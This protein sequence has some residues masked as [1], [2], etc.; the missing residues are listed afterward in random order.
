MVRVL[1]NVSY[2]F[3]VGKMGWNKNIYN[4]IRSGEWFG[5]WVMD[6]ERK[7]GRLGGLGKMYIDRFMRIVLYC[8][9]MFI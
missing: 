1:E 4:F 8:M 9:L 5:Y 7:I 2:W 3:Y 6:M